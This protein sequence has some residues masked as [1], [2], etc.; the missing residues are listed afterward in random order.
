M[1]TIKEWLQDLPIGYR[2]LALKYADPQELNNKR[3]SISDAL[4]AFCSW[5]ETPYPK[6]FIDLSRYYERPTQ[7]QLP[8]LPFPKEY[9]LEQAIERL[10][11]DGFAE[12]KK[13]KLGSAKSRFQ[14]LFNKK[15]WVVI[16]SKIAGIVF[17]TLDIDQLRAAIEA[18]EL[19][20]GATK[21]TV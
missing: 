10:G 11:K 15:E 7:Y 6:F 2:E 14:L 18:C 13:N 3:A 16:D 9:T 4:I 5:D 12:I 17:T 21:E 1:K 20:N 19:L 8:P